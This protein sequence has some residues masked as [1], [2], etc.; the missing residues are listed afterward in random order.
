M[1]KKGKEREEERKSETNEEVKRV[2][3]GGDGKKE[4]R[5]ADAEGQK[6][7]SKEA[8]KQEGAEIKEGRQGNSWPDRGEGGGGEKDREKRSSWRH[9]LL[10]TDVRGLWSQEA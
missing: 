10:C 9:Q 4:G 3:E 5:K 1:A 2:K 7:G 6:D 8:S